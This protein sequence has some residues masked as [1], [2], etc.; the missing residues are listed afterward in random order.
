MRSGSF[1]FP[2]ARTPCVDQKQN[3]LLNVDRLRI[4]GLNQ[5]ESLT[6]YCVKTD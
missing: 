4:N 2:I 6:S 1:T 3:K 5:I